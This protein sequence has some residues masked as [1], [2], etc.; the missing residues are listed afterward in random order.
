[1]TT[2]SPHS[3]RRL[4]Q[5]QLLGTRRPLQHLGPPHRTLFVI[6]QTS[7]TS[8]YTIWIWFF[9]LMVQHHATQRPA[10]RKLTMQQSRQQTLQHES[11]RLCP[12]QRPL[13][14]PSCRSQNYSSVPHQRK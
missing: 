12:K 14:Q 11:T 5:H 7:R 4:L 8:H 9:M 6:E 13:T 3:A 10:M 1:M 2:S